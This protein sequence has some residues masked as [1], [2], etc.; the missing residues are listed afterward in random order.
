MIRSLLR[1]LAAV[2]ALAGL[3]VASAAA[4]QPV[5]LI[6]GFFE[7]GV[8]ARLKAPLAK[9]DLFD[10]AALRVV[11]CGTGSPMPDPARARAC[12]AVIVKGRAYLVDT[13][14]G[15][16]NTLQLMGFPLDHIA[17]VFL[18]HFHS[19][20]IGD[21]GE[22]RM[23][24]WVAGRTAP[25]PIYGPE[26]VSRVIGGFNAAYALDDDYRTLHHDERYM[27]HAAAELVAHSFDVGAS[28]GLVV[29]KD[30]DVTITAFQV[31]HDP[32]KPAVGYRFDAGG[33]SVVVSGDTAPSPNLVKW[34]HGADVLVHEALSTRMV[35]IISRASTAAGL[36]RQAK[37]V[38]DTLNYHTDPVDSAKEANTA[39]VGLLVYSHLAPGL[40]QP[41]LEKL[42]FDGVAAVRDPKTWVVGFDGLRVDLPYAGGAAVQS[43]VA[44]LGR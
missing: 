44:M 10:A 23:Q 36:D 21:L 1:P 16:V 4:A 28:G 31:N 12:T 13:G 22:L 8:E 29:Y 39:G 2:A 9:T 40:P 41:A 38:K 26:G 15:S 17:G 24:T 27:P 5:G 14:P 42:F 11:L 30:A 35:G 20:H 3:T 7:K 34:S 6:A 37:M 33:R 19:D 32:I 43:K 25:L 18:T